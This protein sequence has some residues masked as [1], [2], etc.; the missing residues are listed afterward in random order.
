MPKPIRGSQD[1]PMSVVLARTVRALVAWRHAPDDP[2]V[3]SELNEMIMPLAAWADRMTAGTERKRLGAGRGGGRPAWPY[4][5]EYGSAYTQVVWGMKAAAQHCNVS[6]QTIQNGI[7]KFGLYQYTDTKGDTEQVVT[8]RRATEAEAA[9]Y[10]R[11][12]VAK[13][14]G[15]KDAT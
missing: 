1:L 10:E 6:P 12:A 2:S 11:Q 4:V 7:S 8:V 14:T 5:V 15:T 13:E 9:E 3:R